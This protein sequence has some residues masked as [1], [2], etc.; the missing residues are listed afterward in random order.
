MQSKYHDTVSIVRLLG[1][2]KQKMHNSLRIV[3]N[4]IV[5]YVLLFFRKVEC[6]EQKYRRRK[7]IRALLTEGVVGSRLM[8]SGGA[9]PSRAA[10]L[11]FHKQTAVLEWNFTLTICVPSTP[12]FALFTPH[13]SRLHFQLFLLFDV[14]NN[15]AGAAKCFQV[16]DLDNRLL[17]GLERT[18]SQ[19]EEESVWGQGHLDAGA[20]VLPPAK[21]TARQGPGG[22]LHWK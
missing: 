22:N 10:P 5:S 8:T 11:S 2:F 13:S 7:E 12:T 6:G 20:W 16:W 9:W 1:G 3:H 19:V 14:D 15:L 17:S 4:I 21:Q 18:P